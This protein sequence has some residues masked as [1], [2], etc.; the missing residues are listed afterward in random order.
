MDLDFLGFQKKVRFGSTVIEDTTSSHKELLIACGLYRSPVE[1]ARSELLDA[2]RDGSTDL[3]RVSALVD[4]LLDSQLPFK[5]QQLG[6]GPWQ[7][8][9][10][11]L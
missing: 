9:Y 1:E 10:A 7:V 2:V 6:G 8:R 11:H 4:I 5:E 3:K